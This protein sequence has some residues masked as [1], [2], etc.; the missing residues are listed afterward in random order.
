MLQQ[1][2][3]DLDKAF[4]NF[5]SKRARFP[6]FQSKKKGHFS[7]RIPQRVKVEEGKVYCP[8]VGWIKVRQSQAIEG[9]TKSA[10]F[11]RDACGDWFVAL[12]VEFFMPDTALPEASNPVGR[13][14]RKWDKSLITCVV[15][16]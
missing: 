3:K 10:T 11:K 5:F 4:C 2:V 13:G 9:E 12:T 7:F 8:K 15:W 1:A 16:V 14:Q 6:K